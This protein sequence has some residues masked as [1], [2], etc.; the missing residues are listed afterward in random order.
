MKF[1]VITVCLNSAQTI[2]KTIQSVISQKNVELEYIVVDGGS[3]DET[4][5]VIKK[6]DNKIAKWISEPDKG[7]YDAMNKGIGMA[8]GE[9]ISFLN[10]NDWYEKD[11]FP[12]LENVFEQ[13]RC[14]IVAG[15]QALI[16]DTGIVGYSPKER[17]EEDVY[18]DMIY[19]HPALF[20]KRTLFLEF[21]GFALQYKICADY[22][23]I[24]RVYK[25]GAKIKPLDLVTTN[26]TLGGLSSG[27]EC[28]EERKRISIRHLPESM[29]A[30]CTDKIEELYE[31]GMNVLEFESAIKKIKE[32]VKE[33]EKIKFIL[34]EKLQWTKCCN[35]F[36]AGLRAGE[37]FDILNALDMRTGHVYDNSAI[38]Q[39]MRYRG[40]IIEKPENILDGNTWIIASTIYEDEME[41]QIREMGIEHYVKLSN[42][43]NMV[44]KYVQMDN[45]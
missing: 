14:D 32:C 40:K 2:E 38:R 16:D 27:K 5:D 34:N 41:R 26:F 39:G 29:K 12:L 37:C 33:K 23:W 24:L 30:Q 7:L 36:G 15:R 44:V 31:K 13:E 3:K 11:I 22:D 1:S 42:L 45:E 20:A 6:Y 25:R 35:L 17:A 19:S 28:I 18:I 21:G 10:S 4:L 8:T 43:I 9:I